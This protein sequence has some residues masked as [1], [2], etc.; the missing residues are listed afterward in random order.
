M[1]S[2][3]GKAAEANP[4]GTPGF[5]LLLGTIAALLFIATGSVNE[6]LAV[7]SFFF[8]VM[9]TMSFCSVFVLRR[10]EPD[11]PRPYRTP[12]YPWTTGFSLLASVV[13][14]AGAVA[15]DTKN[16]LNAL[17]LLAVSAPIYLAVRKFRRGA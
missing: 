7:V 16:S 4:G 1:R 10:R 8:V 2:Y 14:L 17:K 11:L 13:F 15:S 5:A 3:F 9:Y 12:G 6:V